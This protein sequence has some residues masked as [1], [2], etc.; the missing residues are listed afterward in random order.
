MCLSRTL[1]PYGWSNLNDSCLE[2]YTHTGITTMAKELDTVKIWEKSVIV[3][4][5]EVPLKKI[6]YKQGCTIL[7]SVQVSKII[8]Q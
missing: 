1:E 5:F 6:L 2:I 3:S 4:K 7:K 8:Y